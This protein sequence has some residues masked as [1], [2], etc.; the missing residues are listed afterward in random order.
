[1]T[2][3]PVSVITIDGVEYEFSRRE[4]KTI[5]YISKYIQE[6]HVAPSQRELLEYMEYGSFQQ[7]WR[8][9]NS[10]RRKG[11]LEVPPFDNPD[12]KRSGGTHRNMV[13]TIFGFKI[14]DRNKPK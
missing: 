8:I 3:D 6:R 13:L 2:A 10:L 11:V 7:T 4:L 14:A 9:A 1:M 5:D 12:D